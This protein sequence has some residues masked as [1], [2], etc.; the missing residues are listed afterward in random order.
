MHALS[1]S[2]LRIAL[3]RCFQISSFVAFFT[4]LILSPT[5]KA[6]EAALSSATKNPLET[7]SLEQK[8]GQLMI[9]TFSGTEF[10]PHLEEMLG[11]Y[12]LGALIAFSRNIQSAT[13]IAKLN[14][15][16]Q[17]FA[18]KNLKAPL[19]MMVDQEGGT[20]TRVRVGTPI[21]VPWL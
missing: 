16:A 1:I 3:E 8:V 13:Q 20:V 14:A 9:W 15:K 19:M 12:Q 4:L 7:M 10:S 11:K 2:K 21:P 5:T 18:R 17:D 6:E